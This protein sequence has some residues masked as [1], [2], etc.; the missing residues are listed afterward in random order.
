M[1]ASVMIGMDVGGTKMAAG[2]V[3]GDGIILRRLRAPTPASDPEQIVRTIASLIDGL[4]QHAPAPPTGVGIAIP[5][6]FD[7][8]SGT[9]VRIANL[10]LQGYPF[11]QR[12]EAVTDLPIAIEN[13]TNAAA[14]GEWF[15][16]SGRGIPDF[17]LVAVG[18]GIGAG[19]I[20]DGRLVRGAHG[21]AGEIGH[22]VVEKDG[23]LCRCGNRG[24]LELFASGAALAER[25]ADLAVRHPG[26]RLAA[27]QRDGHVLS[28]GDLFAA[29]DEGD[30]VSSQ[31]VD[32]AMHYLAVGL[33]NL[34]ELFDPS[35]VAIGGGMS[36]VGPSLFDRLRRAVRAQRPRSPDVATR[37]I[38]AVLGDD[39]GIIGA[40][41]AIRGSAARQG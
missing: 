18:T 23:P 14:L 40:A 9:F 38:P 34:I 11:R 36:H 26:S 25:A 32:E 22:T 4:R 8:R 3:D 7:H 1:A 5:G 37:I 16:G 10:A 6:Q 33:N 12:L 29:A 24:C 15:S 2:L 41:A 30:E 19:V 13:D 21:S 27:R 28:A 17:A 31:A 39:A 35:T 20:L